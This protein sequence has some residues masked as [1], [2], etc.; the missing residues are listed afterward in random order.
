LAVAI[1]LATTSSRTLAESIS[2]YLALTNQMGKILTDI[3]G[4]P[5][6][7][8]VTEADETTYSDKNLLTGVLIKVDV[9]TNDY[10]A[11]VFPR[12]G[13][14]LIQAIGG[15]T[16][17]VELMVVT[18]TPQ[19][20]TFQVIMY[21]DGV[22][23]NG[24]VIQP[25]VLGGPNVTN[26]QNAEGAIQDLTALLFP[27]FYNPDGT[28]KGIGPSPFRVK[29]GSDLEIPLTI[30]EPSSLVLASAS[31]SCVLGH[32]ILRRKPTGPEK[33]SARKRGRSAFSR[34]A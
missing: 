8:D 34:E 21:S 33:G 1:L 11:G 12:S 4:D 27:M 24:E 6:S 15:L 22:K 16:D 30:P 5:A 3:D 14:N 31:L 2:D 26:L 17:T 25:P 19:T 7:G 20:I 13:V 18:S 23:S 9:P 29:A 32:R 28:E 10:P